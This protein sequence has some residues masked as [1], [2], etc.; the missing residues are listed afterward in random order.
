MD[1]EYDQLFY[2]FSSVLLNLKSLKSVFAKSKLPGSRV[3]TLKKKSADDNKSITNYLACKLTCLK[4]L[5]GCILLGTEEALCNVVMDL[6]F[7]HLT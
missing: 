1:A 5:C 7:V 4:T 3:H 2:L 6:F